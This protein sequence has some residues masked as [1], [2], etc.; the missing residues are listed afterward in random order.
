MAMDDEQRTLVLKEVYIAITREHSRLDV[1]WMDSATTT[2]RKR[3]ITQIQKGLR[4]AENIIT[5]LAV[6]R[7]F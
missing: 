3:E 5:N 2:A 1:E 7:H 4:V 6:N